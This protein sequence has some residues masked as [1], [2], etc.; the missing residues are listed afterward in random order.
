MY[1][2][3]D[4]EDDIQACLKRFDETIDTLNIG[5]Y[6]HKHGSI[7]HD[8]FHFIDLIKKMYSDKCNEIAGLRQENQMLKRKMGS[9]CFRGSYLKK[10]IQG[11]H[12]LKDSVCFLEQT[13][14][15]SSTINSRN[16]NSH[17]L[18]RVQEIEKLKN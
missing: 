9:K 4:E 7:G 10:S 12:E 18:Q 8:T 5:Q 1:D 3:D 11:K 14:D 17:L 16:H 2:D 6:Y 13:L 15:M